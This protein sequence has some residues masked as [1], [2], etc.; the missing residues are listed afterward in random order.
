MEIKMSDKLDR[1]T[2][3]AGAA[4]VP[5]LAIP[6][7]GAA[8]AFTAASEP[9][10]VFATVAAHREAFVEHMRA[11]RLDGKLMRSY[12][13]AE[14]TA[15]ALDAADEALEGATLELSEV[16]PTTMAGVVALLRYLE[17]FQEQAIELP[18]APR[19]WHSGDHDA[20]LAETYEHPNLVDKFNG[21]P[22]ELPFV[23]W[24]MQNVRTA[25]QSFVTVQS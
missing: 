8:S 12:P 14:A 23:Y 20:L 22:L 5:A 4:A 25:L 13:G 15:A 3:L 17:E 6:A 10:P 1:R 11:A 21:E 18:E 2:I 19:Q 7:A 24:V 9:D 16:V